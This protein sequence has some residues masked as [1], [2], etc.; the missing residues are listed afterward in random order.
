MSAVAAAARH[1]AFASRRRRRWLAI[2]LLVIVAAGALVAWRLGPWRRAGFAEYPMASASD[3][4]TAIAIGPDGSV[5]ITIESSDAIGVFRNGKIDKLPKGKAERGANG[6]RRGR[7]RRRV[8]HGL[9]RAGGLPH[10]GGRNGHLVRTD[11]QPH[12]EAQPARPRP[13][14]APCGSPT[15]PPSA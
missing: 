11:G 5:W 2:G 3:I 12:R 14:T 15:A 7:R 13:R 9:A 8:V 6:N 10:H 1:T 4:P